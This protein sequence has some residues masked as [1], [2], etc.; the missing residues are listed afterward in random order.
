MYITSD[1]QAIA[2]HP[3]SNAHLALEQ[4][5]RDEFAPPSKSFPHNAM[6]WNVLLASVSQL[7]SLCSLPA[8]WGL[9]CK[10][11]W[12]CA[13]LLSSSYKHWCVISTS[14]LLQ[15]KHSITPGPLKK[16][17]PSQLILRQT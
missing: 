9:C 12:L 15:P 4:R 10:W 5:K 6:A 3:P 8:P 13:V 17:I 7:S 11:P 16:T 14:F 1:A 2:H